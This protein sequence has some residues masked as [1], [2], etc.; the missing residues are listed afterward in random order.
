MGIFCERK[1]EREIFPDI[2]MRD[3]KREIEREGQAHATKE[4]SRKLFSH[5]NSFLTDGWRL[6]AH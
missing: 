2:H 3:R 5:L 1:R 4:C 6:N